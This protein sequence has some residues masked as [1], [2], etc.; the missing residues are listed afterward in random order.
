MQD[1]TFTIPIP[2]ILPILFQKCVTRLRHSKRK[3]LTSMDVNAVI[4]SLCDADP[5]FGGSESMPEYHTEAKVYVPSESVVNLGNLINDPSN[6]TQT[7]VPFLQGKFFKNL[8]IF[9]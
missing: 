8:Y 5:V 9:L 4:T 2:I 1:L 3:R 7:N 6:L